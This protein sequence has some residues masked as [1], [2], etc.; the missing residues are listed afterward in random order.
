MDR[1]GGQPASGR[2]SRRADRDVVASLWAMDDT[3][4]L[5]LMREFYRR[6]A[7]GAD[8]AEALR[9][10]KL[11]MLTSFGPQAVSRLWSGVL[12]YGDG[13]GAVANAAATAARRN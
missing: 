12:V 11:Q 6:L 4:S 2:S 1:R 8:V 13:A 5:A 3:F 9:D 10:A 7:A